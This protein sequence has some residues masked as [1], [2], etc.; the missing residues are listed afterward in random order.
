MIITSIPRAKTS[1]LGLCLWCVAV[2]GLG[3]GFAGG[4]DGCAISPITRQSIVPPPP[5]MLVDR[6]TLPEAAQTA[7]VCDD[8]LRDSQRCSE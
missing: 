3:A 1:L 6:E 2:V 5:G 7:R 4:W 8:M